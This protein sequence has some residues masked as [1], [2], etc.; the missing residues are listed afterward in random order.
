M[1]LL[2]LGQPEAPKSEVLKNEQALWTQEDLLGLRVLELKALLQVWIPEFR[3]LQG[4]ERD[5]PALGCRSPAY[6]RGCYRLLGHSPIG[7]HGSSRPAEF[8]E[9][10]GTDRDRTYHGLRSSKRNLLRHLQE[11]T[12]ALEISGEVKKKIQLPSLSL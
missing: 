10:S 1:V 7:H 9:Q 12:L 4:K 3:W 11:T 2:P 8:K 5:I 6:H